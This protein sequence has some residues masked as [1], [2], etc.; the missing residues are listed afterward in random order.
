[1]NSNRFCS[2]KKIAYSAL[3]LGLSLSISSHSW[4]GC[5]YTITNNWGSGFTGEIKVT[6]N[7]NQTVNGW[8]VS[9]KDSA[10]ITSAWNV[11]LSGANPY[12]ATALSWN[13]T[14]APNASA[15]FGFQGTGNA[16]VAVVTGSL[17]NAVSQSSN[18]ISSSAPSSKPLSSVAPSSTPASS[19]PASSTPQSSI[20]P[21]S[22]APS[23]KSLAS[24][25][26][27]AQGNNTF[28]IQEEQTGFCGV[29]GTVDSNNGGFTGSGFA[30]T[31]NAVGNGVKWAINASSSSRYILSFRFANGGSSNRNGSLLINGGSNGNYTVELPTTGS[32]AA[33]QIASIEV[34]LVQGN[35]TVQLSAL[36]AEGLPNMDY[37][38]VTGAAATPGSCSGAPASSAMATSSVASSS[39]TSSAPPSSSSSTPTYSNERIRIINTTDLNADPDDEQSMVRQLVMANL[40]DIEGLIVSTS[41]WKKTQTSTA[42]LDKLLNAYNQALP[43]L[44]KHADGFPSYEYLKSVSTMGQR[45]YGMGDVGAGKATAGSNLIIA[46]ADKNDARPLWVTCWGGCNTIAQAVWDVRN[47]RSANDFNKFLSKLRIYDVLGQDDAGAWLTKNFPDLFF[48]RATGVY[49][50]APSD[51]WLSTNV[52]SHGALGAAYPN[53]K[54]ATEGD[55]PAFMHLIPN[56]LHDP[57]KV[58]QGGWGGRFDTNKKSG[59]RGMSPVTNEAQYDTYKMFGNTAE[60]TS[61]I[62]RWKPAIDNDFQARMD[63]SIKNNYA[64]AN[65]HPIAVVN[66]NSSTQ[67]LYLNASAGSGVALTAAGSSDPDNN[68]L[69]YA[70][71]YYDEPSSY[72]GSVTIN[73]STSANATVQIPSGASG[74]NLHIILTLRDNGSPNLYAY[75]RVII[76]VQ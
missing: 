58:D 30:N 4:A 63:W 51:S 26:S 48:I 42:A 44:K 17:C 15:S 74:K 62:S 55:S 6:N 27:S 31:D 57:E 7:T 8:S 67:V 38:Q 75:R 46:A 59:I 53:R 24:S 65:H 66:G 61:A 21:S 56:G 47:T 50:W 29:N 40:F 18:A 73:N 11:T 16:S 10:T 41:C 3:L 43:N 54:Y 22:V 35:N 76:N 19:T 72:N 9:W 71:S 69:A 25:S 28:I 2:A 37:L 20:A 23:S 45:G 49:G 70:W 68:G 34:D 33:W 36:T 52:Q 14:L 64:D 39:V 60:G 32:W 5:S 12:T 13:G 1:M